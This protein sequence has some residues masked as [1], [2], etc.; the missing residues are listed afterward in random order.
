[1]A[2]RLIM[3]VMPNRAPQKAYILQPTKQTTKTTTWA[4]ATAGWRRV[5]SVGTEKLYPSLQ[6]PIPCTDSWW[7]R[8][9]TV[10]T[11]WGSR[12]LPGSRWSSWAGCV[13]SYCYRHIRK[14]VTKTVNQTVKHILRMHSCRKI[15]LFSS[16]LTAVTTVQIEW[17][18]HVLLLITLSMLPA[19]NIWTA[20]DKPSKAA[21]PSA[22]LGTVSTH[23][24][25]PQAFID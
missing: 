21:L 4:G 1:M 2:S 11:P 20:L 8:L 25:S 16:C 6:T 5:L 18:F 22:W 23:C 9:A 24:P 17:H 13:T 19:V 7:R 10:W 12:W 3:E 15:N 14:A